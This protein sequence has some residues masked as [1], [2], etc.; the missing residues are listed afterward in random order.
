[1]FK[2]QGEAKHSFMHNLKGVYIKKRDE[3]KEGEQSYYPVKMVISQKKARVFYFKE[4]K[5]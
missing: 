5:M 3:E 4:K 1:V 2:Q